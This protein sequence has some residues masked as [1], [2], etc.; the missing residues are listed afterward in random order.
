MSIFVYTET[1]FS[2]DFP[3]YNTDLTL[4]L[5]TTKMRYRGSSVN[6]LQAQGKD[7]K[8]FTTAIDSFYAETIIVDLFDDWAALIPEVI[9]KFLD[10]YDDGVYADSQ[11]VLVIKDESLI[12]YWELEDVVR[13]F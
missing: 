11:L 7:S 13:K 9:G 1:T 10:D 12:D 8:V 5:S 4:V 6:L 2:Q 3:T